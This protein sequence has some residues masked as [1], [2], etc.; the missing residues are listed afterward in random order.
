MTNLCKTLCVYNMNMYNMYNIYV[1]NIIY[2][3]YNIYIYSII[4]I[5][6]VDPYLVVPKT[7][8]LVQVTCRALLGTPPWANG[9]EEVSQGDRWQNQG[10]SKHGGFSPKCR[11]NWWVSTMFYPKILSKCGIYAY[12]YMYANLAN[13]NGEHVIKWPQDS[14]TGTNVDQ[15]DF[16]TNQSEKMKQEKLEICHIMRRWRK[17]PRQN[18]DFSCTNWCRNM[19]FHPSAAAFPRRWRALRWDVGSSIPHS[20]GSI[21]AAGWPQ[22]HKSV[23]GWKIGWQLLWMVAKSCTSW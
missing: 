18:R 20:T 14:L 8:G 22:I 9:C 17:N 21:S 23:G 13:L 11:N 5:I 1:Y 15:P 7:R 4:N 6:V 19:I 10:L 2:I 16:R 3:I 12:I